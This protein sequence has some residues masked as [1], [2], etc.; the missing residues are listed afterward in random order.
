MPKAAKTKADGGKKPTEK[1]VKQSKQYMDSTAD[2][3][4][5]TNDDYDMRI[6]SYFLKAHR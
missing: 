2:I 6:H 1:Q 4:I 5:A 3:V